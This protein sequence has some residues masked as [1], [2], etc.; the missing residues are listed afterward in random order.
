MLSMETFSYYLLLAFS[1]M[2]L[3]REGGTCNENG[4]KIGHKVTESLQSTVLVVRNQTPT[5]QAEK[6]PLHCVSLSDTPFFAGATR[7]RYMALAKPHAFIYW[8]SKTDGNTERQNHHKDA[9]NDDHNKSAKVRK[10][11]CFCLLA[12]SPGFLKR[13]SRSP[14]NRCGRTFMGT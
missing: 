9:N 8:V 1:P 4:P 10:C 12:R 3:F 14:K 13:H 11:S 2:P 6:I 7:G 5:L